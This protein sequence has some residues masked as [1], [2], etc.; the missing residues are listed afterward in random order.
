MDSLH[1]S[2]VARSSVAPRLDARSLFDSTHRGAGGRPR[3]LLFLLF[4][5]VKLSD[6]SEREACALQT[7]HSL[8]EMR[9]S[10]VD[11]TRRTVVRQRQR[12]DVGHCR[13]AFPSASWLRRTWTVYPSADGVS[14]VRLRQ[15]LTRADGLVPRFG[16]RR[17]RRKRAAVGDCDHRHAGSLSSLLS[18]VGAKV[19]TRS[20]SPP[21][22]YRH[23]K[24]SCRVQSA[25]Q[26]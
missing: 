22:D 10:E 14:A 15:N 18:L 3:T 8:T 25:L 5:H 9:Q 16:A 13:L 20:R 11:F 7:W 2:R 4:L 17:Q 19:R 26:S 12:G 21:L 24:T 23:T 1:S 6:E